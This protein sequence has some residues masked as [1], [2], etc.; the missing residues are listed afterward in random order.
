[1]SHGTL[2]DGCWEYA[3][4]LVSGKVENGDTAVHGGCGYTLWRCAGCGVV[5]SAT[6]PISVTH[7]AERER[8]ECDDLGEIIS[9]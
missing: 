3:Q 4:V 7:D 2:P 6:G 1:M 8:W 5:R 9:G